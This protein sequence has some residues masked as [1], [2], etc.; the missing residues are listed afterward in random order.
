M[1]NMCQKEIFAMVK[2]NNVQPFATAR[3]GDE[4]TVPVLSIK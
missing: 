3:V 1:F 2:C 4:A